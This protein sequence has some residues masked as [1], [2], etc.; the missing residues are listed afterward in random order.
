MSKDDD[1]RFDRSSTLGDTI[2]Q[3]CQLTFRATLRHWLRSAGFPPPRVC[4]WDPTRGLVLTH[5][6]G[7]FM[8]CVYNMAITFHA[9]MFTDGT[10]PK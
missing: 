6:Y 4:V 9:H 5:D 8:Y 2:V 1:A 10:L 7:V 3:T